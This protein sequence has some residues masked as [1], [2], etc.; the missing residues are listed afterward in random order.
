MLMNILKR[1]ALVLAVA[2]LPAV[3]LGFSLSWSFHQVFGTPGHIE[4]AL[5][6]SGIYNTIVPNV[7]DQAQQKLATD[8]PGSSVSNVPI[9]QPAIKQIIEQ[10]IPPQYL[11]TQ[12]NGVIN[13]VYAWVHGQKPR[14]AFTI[15]LTVPKQK[16]ADGLAAYVTQ[17][18]AALPSCGVALQGGDVDPFNATCIPK[19]YDT[20]AA[21][22]KVRDQILSGDFLKNSQLTADTIKTGNGQTLG[23]KLQ[24]VPGIYHKVRL[25]I[26]GL[27]I[28]ALLLSVAVVFCSVDWRHGLRKLGCLYLPVGLTIILMTWL[29][30]FGLNK[31]TEELSKQS[32]ANQAIQQSILSVA[33]ILASDLRTYWL[34]AG[35]GLVSLAVAGFVAYILTKPKG[36]AKAAPA[37]TE[38]TEKSKEEVTPEDMLDALEPSKPRKPRKIQ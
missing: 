25:G 16:L 3:L 11:Q 37:D 35:I 31:A 19:G 14:L 38:T 4:S 29:L 8:N 15:D 21:G 9:D 34:T 20:V 24:P 32:S 27:G 26:A 10:S 5:T 23:Q 1:I 33:K 2:L 18:L 13:N 22:N 12:V 28:V 17:H 36:L 6:K 30:S 7:L